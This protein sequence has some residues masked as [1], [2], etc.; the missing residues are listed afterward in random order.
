MFISS[1]RS[2]LNEHDLKIML[3]DEYNLSEDLTISFWR[4][5]IAGNDVYLIN[6][7]QHYYIMKVYYINIIPEQVYVS[8][9]LMEFLSQQMAVIPHIL[10][11]RNMDLVTKLQCP[12]GIRYAVVFERILGKEPDIF[13]DNDAY[14]IGKTVGQMYRVFDDNDIKIINRSID[15]TF[16]IRRALN[17][18]KKYLP[19][20]KMQ[21]SYFFDIG[22]RLEELFK[23]YTTH[24]IPRYG[25]C[26][27]DLHTGNMIK[28]SEEKI[29]IFDFDACGL[30]SRIYD[31]G[32]YAND[33]WS[34][35]TK[36]EL[37]K[38][39]EALNKFL[40]GY[41]EYYSLTTDEYKLF[42][43]IPGIRHFEMFGTVLKNCIFLEG[44][45]WV[46]SCYQFHYNWFKAWESNIDWNL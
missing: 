31:I 45:H 14:K 20:K 9:S 42:P 2:L 33:N 5:G 41:N 8:T 19:G 40:K 29:F 21:I 12:E 28:T 37:E 22:H 32:I 27:G 1:K 23:K 3:S 17:D 44:F 10:R 6:T 11:N 24:K 38:D 35:T 39:Y 18:I 4:T 34:K 13:D 7:I 36:E 15:T 16:L 26:H 46:E 30:G 43:I 25:I